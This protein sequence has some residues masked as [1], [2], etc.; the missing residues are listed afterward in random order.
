MTGPAGTY[1]INGTVPSRPDIQ[2]RREPSDTSARLSVSRH[3]ADGSRQQLYSGLPDENGIYRTED[4]RAVARLAGNPTSDLPEFNEQWIA[5]LPRAEDQTLRIA[6]STTSPPAE[7]EAG[8]GGNPIP[9]RG[10]G[11]RADGDCD[12]WQTTTPPRSRL[13]QS[14]GR[15]DGEPGNSNWYSSRPE[16][17]AITGGQPI[18]FSNGYADFTPWSRLS[19]NFARGELTGT[20][21]ADVNIMIRRLTGGTNPLFRDARAVRDFLEDNRLTP[22][23][24]SDSCIQLVPRPLNSLIPHVGSASGL[25]SR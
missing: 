22:H 13:P 5:T 3:L 6:P 10:T 8:H 12:D 4:G 19:I 16:V 21:T 14:E 25:R 9:P 2:F 23:H 18:R 24:A 7:P 1:A 15:W 11:V 20:H 17:N